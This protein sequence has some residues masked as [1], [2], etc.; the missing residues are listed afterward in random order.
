[1]FGDLGEGFELEFL[2]RRGEGARGVKK[3]EMRNL[4]GVFLGVLLFAHVA[5]CFLG[6]L[7]GLELELG[8]ALSGGEDGV[9]RD[10]D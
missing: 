4:F 5:V 1:M 9:E 6:A 3:V 8:F 10:S 2:L 7:E